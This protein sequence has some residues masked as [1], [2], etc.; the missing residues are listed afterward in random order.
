VPIRPADPDD[1][2]FDD[3]RIRFYGV[4]RPGRAEEEETERW[5]ED[6]L[7]CQRCG[8]RYPSEDLPLIRRVFG[9]YAEQYAGH[10]YQCCT[11]FHV[12]QAEPPPKPPEG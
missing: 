7:T 2:M 6:W 1:P 4:V 5:P 12:G 10:C 9:T 3:D 8:N 11:L